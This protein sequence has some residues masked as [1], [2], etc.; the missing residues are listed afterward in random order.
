MKARQEVRESQRV[1]RAQFSA[2]QEHLKGFERAPTE[3]IRTAQS[4]NEE[5]PVAV[6]PSDA[7]NY[8]KK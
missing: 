7:G 6:Q 4:S 5:E 8:H 3:R 2:F 1:Q